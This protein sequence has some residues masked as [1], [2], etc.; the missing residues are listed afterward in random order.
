MKYLLMVAFLLI[1]PA[2]LAVPSGPPVDVLALLPMLFGEYGSTIATWLAIVLA[3]WTQ[4]RTFIPARWL[5]KLP[6]PVID[7][8]ERAAGN[9]GT[10]SNDPWNDPAHVKRVK[11]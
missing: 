3:I 1:A 7:W 6:Q 2:A 4:V 9:R 5:A 10:A 8:L 11:S